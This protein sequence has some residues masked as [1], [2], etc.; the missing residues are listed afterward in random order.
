MRSFWG[1]ILVLEWYNRHISL[2]KCEPEID[3][4]V[5]QKVIGDFRWL[6]VCMSYSFWFLMLTFLHLSIRYLQF[7]RLQADW[8]GEFRQGMGCIWSASLHVWLRQI[9]SF[10]Y[11]HIYVGIWSFTV[12]FL[13]CWCHLL[14][15]EC[16]LLCTR[17]LGT[18]NKFDY[19]FCLRSNSST[20]LYD[21]CDVTWIRS[22]NLL[23][24]FALTL[25]IST[26]LLEADSLSSQRC[27]VVE[28]LS[29]KLA[30]KIRCVASC[31]FCQL[32]VVLV[33]STDSNNITPHAARNRCIT[34]HD[35]F[36]CLFG[37]GK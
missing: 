28:D 29:T 7:P 6:F 17:V 35:T 36:I 21:D 1:K 13:Y 27:S 20:W 3:L 16:V 30:C 22:F 15:P 23:L 18:D 32:I 8:R 5:G 12:Q 2:T 33:L 9:Y 19:D 14:P 24:C 11:M 37:N 4:K 10:F 34:R 31:L 26:G 25:L